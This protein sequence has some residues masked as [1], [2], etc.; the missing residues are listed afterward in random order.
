MSAL[1]D[2]KY[3]KWDKLASSLDASVTLEIAEEE[4]V[5]SA[6]LGHDNAWSEAEKKE[7]V[8]AE[9]AKRAKAALDRQR[10]LEENAKLVVDAAFTEK[11]A[12][13]SNDNPDN[14]L[15]TTH[16]VDGKKIIQFQNIKKP[17]VVTLAE[18]F[19]AGALVKLFVIDCD[20][21]TF[22]VGV[23]LLTGHLEIQ[24]CTKCCVNVVDKPLATVQIDLSDGCE[25]N[26]GPGLFQGVDDRVYS[27]GCTGLRISA[28]NSEVITD[29]LEDGAVQVNE[30]T[31]KE[32]QFVA[33]YSAEK[34]CIINEHLMRV[35]NKFL[36]KSTVENADL[37]E[38]AKLAIREQKFGEAEQHKLEGNDAFAQGEYAQ[39]VL[40]YTMAIDKIATATPRPPLHHV[41]LSNRSACFLKL[42]HHEKALKDASECV[43]LE[44]TFIK[45]VFRKGMALH[46]M[47]NYEEALPVLAE[48]MKLEPNNK[49]VKQ[50]LQFCEIKLQQEMRKRMQGSNA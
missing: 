6:A 4:A 21:V 38:A 18:P 13:K 17:C 25:I 15:L 49:Q 45:G 39:A 34:Q 41:C 1:H 8:K 40:F 32:Y 27:A 36:T 37:D 16:L 3:N 28:N 2:A 33:R 12:S 20:N 10:D 7:K 29:Y 5:A 24:R 47:G 48:S 42:G 50:A 22:N 30:N 19:V 44:P 31:D 43:E 11:H 14:L 23:K 26:Y 46:A 35:G 9:Q